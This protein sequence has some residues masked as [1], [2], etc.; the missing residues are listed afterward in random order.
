MDPTG[1][2]RGAVSKVTAIVAGSAVLVILLLVAFILVAAIYYQ[3]K[4]KPN[5]ARTQRGINPSWYVKQI[6]SCV[7][8][9]PD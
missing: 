4:K 5:H 6:Q 9:E 3:G 2:S 1:L 8:F 7:I